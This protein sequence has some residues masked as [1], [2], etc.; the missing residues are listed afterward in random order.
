MMALHACRVWDLGVGG[1]GRGGRGRGRSWLGK[2]EG[3]E[4]QTAAWQGSGTEGGWETG[5]MVDLLQLMVRAVDAA[6]GGQLLCEGPRY[7]QNHAF[8]GHLMQV[9]GWGPGKCLPRCCPVDRGASSACW[10]CT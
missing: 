4:V 5:A 9:A 10:D 2:W 7:S 1:W 6:L 3:C 8:G